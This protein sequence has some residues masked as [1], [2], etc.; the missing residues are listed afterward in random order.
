MGLALPILAPAGV[1]SALTHWGSADQQATYLQGVRRRE[2]APGLRGDRRTAAAVRPDRVEDHRGAHPQRLPPR[3][4]QVTGSRR[5]ER[6]IVHRGSTTQRQ[7][8]AVH[9]RVV[10]EGR[11]RHRRTRAWVFA[12]RRSAGSNSTTSRCRCAARLGEDG[13]HR[14][15]TT[16]RPSPCRASAGR[17]W[18]SAPRTRC[19]TTWCPT[20]RS[21]RHSASR[22]PTGRRWRSCAPTSRSNSTGC[23]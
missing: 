7:A 2:R 17:R 18:R 1:A 11:H 13:R 6:R 20:S 23:G 16:R 9:R 12:R 15:R 14:R 4:R 10:G 21:A 3:R 19:S 22:S 8:R 5:C